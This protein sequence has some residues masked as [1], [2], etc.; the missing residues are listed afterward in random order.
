MIALPLPKP[1]AYRFADLKLDLRERRL[2]RGEQTIRVG[3]LTYEM[4]RALVEQAPRVVTHERL[5]ERVW[6]GRYVSPD[7]LTQRVK[8]LRE[9]LSDVARAPRYVAA[10]RGYGYRLAPEVKPVTEAGRKPTLAV[11]PFQVLSE[12]PRAE[13]FAAGMHEEVVSRIARVSTLDVLSRAPGRRDER[14]REPISQIVAELG[15]NVVVEGSVR[16]AAG[17]VRITAQIIDATS[18]AYLWADAFDCT[19]D[20]LEIQVYVAHEI[21]SAIAGVGRSAL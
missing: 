15:V 4:L 10:V 21:A 5:A 18:S 13:L 9:A 2:S 1:V 20:E 19:G 11:L 16:Y 17:R 12:E 6:R 14:C 7:T 3:R 8:L